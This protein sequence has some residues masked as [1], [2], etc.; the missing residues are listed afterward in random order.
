MG[1]GPE[2]EAKFGHLVLAKEAEFNVY[3]LHF[4]EKHSVSSKGSLKSV[5]LEPP[6]LESGTMQDMTE[7]VFLLCIQVM[8]TDE[9]IGVLQDKLHPLR[10]VLEHPRVSRPC[11]HFQAADGIGS[12]GSGTTCSYQPS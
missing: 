4:W 5:S 12:S 7:L 9:Q 1:S 2:G 10:T 11:V 6:M 3:F 8:S